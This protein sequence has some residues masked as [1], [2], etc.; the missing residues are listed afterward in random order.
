MVPG[1]GEEREER[2]EGN[3]EGGRQVGGE[4]GR[5]KE[6]RDRGGRR[7]RKGVGKRE[8]PQMQQKIM[9]GEEQIPTRM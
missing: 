1:E 7:R 8:Q 6:G 9:L 2:R 3:G 4:G 5:E